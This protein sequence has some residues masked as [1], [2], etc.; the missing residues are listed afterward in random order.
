MSTPI[1]FRVSA[2]V[3]AIM[4]GDIM[5]CQLPYQTGKSRNRPQRPQSRR[6]DCP[7]CIGKSRQL[8][9]PQ[10]QTVTAGFSGETEAGE[11][12]TR[13]VSGT[14]RSM[15]SSSSLWVRSSVNRSGV[16]ADRG[17]YRNRSPS[18]SSRMPNLSRLVIKL[19]KFIP[20][21]TRHQ[22]LIDLCQRYRCQQYSCFLRAKFHYR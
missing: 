9:P 13:A 5:V 6:T 17:K 12:S 16:R 8:V 3:E 4:C 1:R 19:V 10:R 21:P 7:S 15:A 22:L 18:A 14:G 20:P 11:G 2:V